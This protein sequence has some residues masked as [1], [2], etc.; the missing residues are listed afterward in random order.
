MTTDAIWYIDH[1]RDSRYAVVNNTGGSALAVEVSAHGMTLI[2]ANR[3]VVHR[4]DR[5]EQ[6][7]RIDF[8]MNTKIWGADPAD[9]G[10]NV[11][12]SDDVDTSVRHQAVCLVRHI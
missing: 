9:Q 10:V 1:I 7:D 3:H 8:V 4:R 6:G 2:G 12:W 11:A 5:L